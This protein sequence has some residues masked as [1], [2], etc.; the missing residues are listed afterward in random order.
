MLFTDP[1]KPDAFTKY[2]LP[3]VATLILPP[4]RR[5]RS[6]FWI[7]LTSGA[8]PNLRSASQPWLKASPNFPCCL[9]PVSTPLLR[10]NPR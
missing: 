4:L 9:C 3:A 2:V 1:T 5:L 8:A 6:G 10:R 7:T